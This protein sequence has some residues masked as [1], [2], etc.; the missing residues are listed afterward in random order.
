MARKK[1][2]ML[3]CGNY[4]VPQ[5]RICYKHVQQKYRKD[6]PL[7]YRYNAYVQNQKKQRKPI[8]TFG[9]WK[10]TKAKLDLRLRKNK[11]KYRD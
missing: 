6:H 9:S 10:T 2:A 8:L 4:A 11:L 1:C 7:Q 5:R 3:G